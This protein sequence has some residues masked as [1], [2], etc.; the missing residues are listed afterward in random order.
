MGNAYLPILGV[1]FAISCQCDAQ[2]F[3]KGVAEQR[4]LSEILNP[5][6]DKNIR[7]FS[8]DTAGDDPTI[9]IINMYVRSIKDIDE[10]KMLWSNQLTFRMEWYDARLAYYSK[11]DA[12]KLR[13]LTLTDPSRVWIP[14]LFFSNEVESH[15]HELLYSNSYTRIFPDGRILHS[16]RISLT[17]ACPMAL[18]TYPFDLQT[19]SMRMASYGHT[20]NDIIFKWKPDDP[21]QISPS[22]H[23][24]KFE[25]SQFTTDYCD[26]HTNTGVY[27]CLRVELLFKRAFS[28]Y[29][30]QVY[31]PCTMLVIIAWLTLWLE[32]HG[33]VAVGRLIMGVLTLLVNA[34][35]VQQMNITGPVVSYTKAIDVWTGTC[36]TFVFTTIIQFILVNYLARNQ[37]WCSSEG[38][39]KSHTR[40]LDEIRAWKH[41]CPHVLDIIARILYPVA[42]FFFVCVYFGYYKSIPY[43]S[44]S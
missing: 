34:V 17:L 37:I 40:L 15:R 5:S 19:C 9:V 20:T 4:I 1:L 27:S 43:D 33:P 32:H 21:V 35:L 26:S 42:F 11:K 24:S 29:L 12:D 6:Y 22:L 10:V 41:H 16:T 25:L 7:A 18:K 36:L 30:V 31:I 44:D 2:R 14:D 13:Y 23:L 3:H 39:I 28:S 8:N 38:N